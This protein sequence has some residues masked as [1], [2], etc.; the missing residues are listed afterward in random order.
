MYPY[1]GTYSTS[2]LPHFFVLLDKKTLENNL[3]CSLIP[4]PPLPHSSTHSYCSIISTLHKNLMQKYA[5]RSAA[6]STLPNLMLNLQ[7]PSDLF[8]QQRL[9]WLIPSFFFTF[10][11]WLSGHPLFWSPP[12]SLA[13][14]SQT[15]LSSFPEFSPLLP[16]LLSTFTASVLS[17]SPMA[18]YTVYNLRLPIFIFPTLI[19]H[20]LSR[21]LCLSSN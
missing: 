9:P 12:T 2:L 18:L 16:C 17:S 14:P 4:F 21:F 11:T 5:P 19:M 3:L 7:P 10:F 20:L 15:P 8:S 1:S 6:A 13:S